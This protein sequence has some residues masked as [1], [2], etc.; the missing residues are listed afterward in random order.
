MHTVGLSSEFHPWVSCQYDP[1]LVG[2]LVAWY[3]FPYFDPLRV[4]ACFLLRGQ[5]WVRVSFVV[6]GGMTGPCGR[7]FQ[8]PMAKTKNAGMCMGCT[9]L[10]LFALAKRQV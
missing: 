1:E 3:P 8:R 10:I 2:C 9:S 5:K 4:T 6:T 7:P